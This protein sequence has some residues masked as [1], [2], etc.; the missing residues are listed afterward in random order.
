MKPVK[1]SSSAT[2]GESLALRC[3]SRTLGRRAFVASASALTRVGLARSRVTTAPS[4]KTS[5]VVLG[6]DAGPKKLELIKKH[7]LKTLD[8]DGF[9]ALIGDRKADPNDPKVL[10]AK[11]KEEAKV[12]EAAK[13]LTLAKDAP[14]VLVAFPRPNGCLVS[15][16]L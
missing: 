15:S 14:Y 11:K 13:A 10:E 5:Y 8:E 3:D 9:L 7:K 1:I 2:E 4:S 6:S 12:K 16:S